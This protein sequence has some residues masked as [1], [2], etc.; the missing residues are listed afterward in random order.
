MQQRLQGRAWLHRLLSFQGERCSRATAVPFAGLASRLHQ[1][2]SQ[3]AKR[4][5]Y[6]CRT[7]DRAT[8]TQTGQLGSRK[9][10]TGKSVGLRNFCRER[11]LP[12]LPLSWR[13]EKMMK[14]SI[15]IALLTAAVWSAAT[16]SAAL[17]QRGVGQP[18]GVAAS[19]DRPTVVSIQGRVLEVCTEPCESTTGHALEGTHFLLET[20]EGKRLNMHLGPADAVADIAAQLAPRRRVTVACF[21]TP[22]MKP[23]HYVAQ[24]IRIGQRTLELRDENLRPVWAG[25]IG[26]G[27]GRGP[28]AVQPGWQGRGGRGGGRGRG[29]GGGW[30]RGRAAVDA[31]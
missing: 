6:A 9:I 3:D 19:A 30:G 10:L 15:R 5:G 2:Q 16:V 12:P 24:S 18:R 1:Q 26:P 23:D 14:R 21:R 8:V 13:R 11:Q 31:P 7:F 28:G 29:A 27:A 25:T 4:R 20:A 17:A 22:R